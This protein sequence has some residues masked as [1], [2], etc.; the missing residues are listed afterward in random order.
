MYGIFSNF[1]VNQCRNNGDHNAKREEKE[2]DLRVHRRHCLARRFS[3]VEQRRRL[4]MIMMQAMRRRGQGNHRKRQAESSQ[5]TIS[6]SMTGR[7]E[8]RHHKS[9]KLKQISHDHC[10]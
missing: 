1:H 2:R 5:R 4:W 9:E 8:K 10:E 3:P 7:Q 6:A